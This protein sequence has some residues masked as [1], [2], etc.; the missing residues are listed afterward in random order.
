MLIYEQDS[1]AATITLNRP[2]K[3]NA[4]SKELRDELV[5]CLDKIECNEAID[6]AILTGSGPSFCA[7]FDI[8]EFQTGDIEAVFKQAVAYHH[9]VYNFTKPLI[10]AVNGKALAGGMDLAA[11]CDLRIISTES[12]FGQP[13]VKMGIDAAFDLMSTVLPE[14]VAREICLTG[15]IMSCDEALN[16]NFANE[17]TKPQELLIRSKKIAT[18]ISETGNTKKMKAEFKLL[19]PNLFSK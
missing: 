11:M 4:L 10:A 5:N 14:T 3:H 16:N 13:Q 18:E 2:D 17:I 6:V 9:K 15:R 8:S 12:S 7:G 19:Q 1:R